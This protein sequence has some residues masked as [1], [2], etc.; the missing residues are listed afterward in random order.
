[1]VSREGRVCLV[2]LPLS[3]TRTVLV[4]TIRTVSTTDN[5]RRRVSF[6]MRRWKPI[7]VRNSSKQCNPCSLLYY[8]FLFCVFQL[9]FAFSE[10]QRSQQIALKLRNS[11]SPRLG[12]QLPGGVVSHSESSPEDAGPTQPSRRT[13]R[14]R[15]QRKSAAGT[16]RDVPGD[17]PSPSKVKTH[18]APMTKR[19][20]YFSLR[21]GMVRVGPDGLESAVGRVTVVNWENQVVLDEYVQVS[22]PVFDHRT[23]VTG[24]TPKNLHEATLSL[25]AARNKTG[26][27]LKGKILIGHGLEVDLSALGLTH[28]WCDVR[29]TANYAA[30]MRQVKDQLSVMTLPRDLDDLLRDMNLLPSHSYVHSTNHA[31]GPVVEAVGCLDLYK[32]V[33]KEWEEQ[34][35]QLVQQKERQ[36]AMLLSMR[37]ARTG[38]PYSTNTHSHP[39]GKALSSIREDS[40]S[41][42]PP[43]NVYTT[44]GVPTQAPEYKLAQGPSY[45]HRFDWEESTQGST[46]PTT[47]GQDTCRDDVSESSGYFSKDSSSLYSKDSRGSS[48]FSRESR[49][50]GILSNES[51]GNGRSFF[52][53]GRRQRQPQSSEIENIQDV[54]SGKQFCISRGAQESIWA[55]QMAG[56]EEWPPPVPAGSV[57]PFH[58]PL[59]TE[60]PQQLTHSVNTGPPQPLSEHGGVGGIW[61]PLGTPVTGSL[62]LPHPVTAVNVWAPGHPDTVYSNTETIIPNG[63]GEP[64]GLPGVPTEE[65]LM[66]RLPSHLLAD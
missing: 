12:P 15:R 60:I 19:D 44:G 9:G 5:G 20:L 22:V 33:R 61:A 26:L 57:P 43:A 17:L 8:C 47:I 7:S 62:S 66:E 55:D 24:I 52:S 30:Y 65:E 13:R 53:F 58:Q 32:A 48:F 25:A 4:F 31:F 56:G 34:L 21:C 16:S 23:G 39:Q 49:G 51:R 41:R 40:V 35:V 45:G 54:M 29:D 6:R 63:I 50:S 38:V 3:A 59:S 46:E 10:A 18:D 37:S 64:S 11:Q 28:P 36:R 14:R 2:V 1:M 27:L 42:S